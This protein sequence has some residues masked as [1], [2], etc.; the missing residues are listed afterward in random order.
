[1]SRAVVRKTIAAPVER[2]FETLADVESFAQ[3]IPHSVGIEFLSE[4]RSG[5]GPRFRETRQTG[6]RKATT[7]LEITECV[8]NE[9]LRMVAD[10]HGSIWDSLFVLEE[11]AGGTELTVTMEAKAHQLVARLMNPMVMPAIQSAMESDLDSVKRY[12]EEAA[13]RG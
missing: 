7:E 4:R 12:C 2:V 13:A 1:M 3:A 11:V 8:P 10:S 6:S 5:V 9:R